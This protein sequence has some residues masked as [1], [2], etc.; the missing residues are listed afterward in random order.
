MLKL[1]FLQDRKFKRPIGEFRLCITCASANKTPLHRACAELLA[2]L[3]HDATTE[4]RYLASVCELGSTVETSDLGFTFRIQGFDDKIL[5]LTKEIL[6]AFFSFRGDVLPPSVKPNRFHACLEV[7]L[8][9]Y[10]NSGMKA[11]SLCSDIRLRCLRPTIWSSSAK[12][13]GHYRKFNQLMIAS[14]VSLN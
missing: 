10:R 13:R 9:R 5:T 8:R 14:N 3:L 4:T 1:W 6:N 11:S 7:L 12:V 2:I